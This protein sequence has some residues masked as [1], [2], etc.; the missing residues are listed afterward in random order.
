M[1]YDGRPLNIR[2]LSVYI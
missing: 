1:K 2:A